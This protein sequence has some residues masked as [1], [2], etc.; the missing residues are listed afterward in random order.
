MLTYEDLKN[1][2]KELVAAT[3]LKREEIE[4]LLVGFGAAYTQQYPAEQT[5]EGEI[6]QRGVGG[7]RKGKLACLEDKLLFI[8]MYEKT[9]PLQTVFGLQFGLSQG[10]VNYWIHR[11]TPVLQQTLAGMGMTPE[12]D[13]Q[14]VQS[15]ALAGERGANLGLDVT[16]P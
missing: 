10:R 3:G 1:K 7:G 5:V 14:A 15:S 8:L 9:Y 16:G 13:A 2:P 11:L 6:R 4:A 12:R